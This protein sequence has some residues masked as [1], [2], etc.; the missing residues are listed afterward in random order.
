MDVDHIRSLTDIKDMNLKI[1]RRPVEVALTNLLHRANKYLHKNIIWLERI[2]AVPGL[3][4]LLPYSKLYK[5]LE[6][7]Y[8]NVRNDAQYVIMD[9]L[10]NIAD[11][12]VRI[13][14]DINKAYQYALT[15][16]RNFYDPE[17]LNNPYKIYSRDIAEISRLVSKF[18][19]L[20]ITIRFNGVVD[21]EL[22]DYTIFSINP[23]VPGCFNPNIL[24]YPLLAD[25]DIYVAIKRINIRPLS[26]VMTSST[27][28]LQEL[29][30]AIVDDYSFFNYDSES[31]RNIHR[32][33]PNIC[34]FFK[35]GTINELAGNNSATFY[36]MWYGF[37][38]DFNKVLLLVDYAK[39]N[40]AP[41]NYQLVSTTKSEELHEVDSPRGWSLNNIL[42]TTPERLQQI[43]CEDLVKV[44]DK[45]QIIPK[46]DLLSTLRDCA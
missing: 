35:S 30:R 43:V 37:L 12:Q 5:N 24:S 14:N 28:K 13:T 4:L 8:L 36:W 11:V 6:D 41:H 15:L 2:R 29:N 31:L 1:I 39:L 40:A 23:G 20:R 44:L 19:Q 27:S 3:S 18:Y 32:L 17:D 25:R 26:E 7:F 45:S 21:G 33:G 16:I 46:V 38:N 9:R 42:T 34:F 22:N 10:S